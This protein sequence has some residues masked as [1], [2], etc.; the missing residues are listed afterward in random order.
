MTEQR[1]DLHPLSRHFVV[2][3]DLCLLLFCLPVFEV[4]VGCLKV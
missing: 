2:L 4:L 1:N 3:V